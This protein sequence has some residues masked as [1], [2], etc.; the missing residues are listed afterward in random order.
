[1]DEPPKHRLILT[2][3]SGPDDLIGLVGAVF[4]LL[5]TF[6]SVA[7]YSIY[8][9]ERL[10]HATELMTI[11]S[12][13]AAIGLG[14]VT[15]PWVLILDR[16]LRNITRKS[17]PFSSTEAIR[18]IRY[19]ALYHERIH[20]RKGIEVSVFHVVIEGAPSIP[21]RT[22]QS[23]LPARELGR[24]IADHLSV[25]F[26]DQSRELADHLLIRD[27]L[28]FERGRRRL[29]QFAP[30]A[31][32]LSLKSALI[33]MVCASLIV[34]IAVYVSKFYGLFAPLV[35]PLGSLAMGVLVYSLADRRA[36]PTP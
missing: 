22:F 23:L 15:R 6:G 7:C 8:W 25:P 18:S 1:M 21:I 27:V 31:I 2:L 36:P 13:V 9:V 20:K 28:E 29:S 33:L 14:L 17:G 19:I 32:Q 24:K 16:E 35:T 3:D 5:G 10:P 11:L 30:R 4:L 26:E 34:G 12:V